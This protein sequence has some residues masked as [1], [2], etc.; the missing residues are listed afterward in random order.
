V[1]GTGCVTGFPGTANSLFPERYDIWAGPCADAKVPTTVDLIA[2][3]TDGSTASVAMASAVVDVKVANVST[4]GK[5]VYAIHAAEAPAPAGSVS[6]TTQVVYT[7]PL[8]LVGGTKVLLPYGTWTF[9]LSPTGGT[10]SVTVTLPTS[11]S[12]S[13]TLTSAT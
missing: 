3:S 5:T 8:T 2:P 13:V 9:S 12:A 10:G 11:G 7:L 6:C 1:A 4:A